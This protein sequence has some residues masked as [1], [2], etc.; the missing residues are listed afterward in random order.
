MKKYESNSSGVRG[1]NMPL[2]SFIYLCIQHLKIQFH[3][4]ITP[5]NYHFHTLLRRKLHSKELWGLYSSLS[6]IGIIKSRRMRLSGHVARM[7]V[8]R[9]AYRL[10]VGKPEGRRPLRR[11]RRRRVDNIKM[12]IVELGWGWVDWIGLAQDRHKW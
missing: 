5:K 6:I 8:K 2:F 1:K 3:L 4:H 10:L 7:G 12:D 11:A 9:T